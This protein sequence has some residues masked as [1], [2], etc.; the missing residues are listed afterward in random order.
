M[1]H[2]NKNWFVW[3]ALNVEIGEI[4]LEKYDIAIVGGGIAGLSTALHIC[5]K[6]DAAILLVDKNII[7]NPTKTSPFTFPDI[8]HR[9]HLS[10]AVLQRYKRFTYRSPT[11]I[12]AS[13]EYENTAFVTLDYHKAC[14]IMLNRIRKEANVRVLEKT[15]ASDLEIFN[16]DLKLTLS[17]STRISCKV[18]VDASGSSF[19]ASR[20]LRIRLPNFYSHPY[21][22]L[23][24]GCKIEDPEEICIFAGKKYGNGGGWLYPINTKTA[25][26]G[27]ATITN[28]PIYPKDTVEENFRKAIQDFYPYNIMLASSKRKRSEFGTIPIGP[29]KKFVYGQIVIV[30]DAAGQATSWYNEGIRP[31]LE[32]GEICGNTIAEAYE[33]GKFREATLIK[34]QHL[35]DVKNR[36]K[37]SI[38]KKRAAKNFFRNQD[39]WDNSVRYQASL[40]PDEMMAIIRYNRWPISLS[41]LCSRYWHRVKNFIRR[42]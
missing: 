18:L 4:A 31:A 21:G 3:P 24:D 9:F 15:E 2:C 37:Y 29:L 22:E 17:N 30:G 36:K 6:V 19:F 8:V 42:A 39:Q 28:S 14:N 11:G 33:K 41:K 7:G 27:F 40:A 35:W 23:L 5:R 10:D 12:T 32:S 1:T 13:F 26:F 34:Y 20:K 16:T 25:R 38:D